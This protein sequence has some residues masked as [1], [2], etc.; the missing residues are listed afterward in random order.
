A[1]AAEPAKR[2]V[3]RLVVVL[4]GLRPDSITAEDTPTLYRLRTE[5]VWFEN[6]H[7]VFPTVTRVNAASLGTGTYPARHGIMGNSIY[8]PAVDP[9]KAF[10]N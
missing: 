3:L 2:A 1:H 6:S 8:V 9:L 5:G 10:S 7:A 4:D